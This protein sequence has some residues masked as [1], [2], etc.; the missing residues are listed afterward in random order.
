MAKYIDLNEENFEASTSQGVAVV[1]FWASWC[2][3]CRL[4][5]PVIKELAEEFDGKANICKVNTDEN[6]DISTRFG[7]SSIPTIVIM[8]DGEVVETEVGAKSKQHLS[9]LINRHL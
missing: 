5:A 1:D 4:I 7:V 9:D 6:V 3:P 8:K 2:G